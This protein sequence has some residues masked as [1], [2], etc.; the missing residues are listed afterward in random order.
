MCVCTL[1]GEGSQVRAGGALV[2]TQTAMYL[3]SYSDCLARVHE[4]LLPPY[5]CHA[6]L[7]KCLAWSLIFHSAG[8][9][10]LDRVSVESTV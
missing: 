6:S 5:R 9:H 2:V 4:P 3:T 8:M 7:K 10:G 1:N